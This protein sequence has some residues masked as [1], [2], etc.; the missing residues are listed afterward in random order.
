MFLV[1]HNSMVQKGN[2]LFTYTYLL[3]LENDFRLWLIS[4]NP[5]ILVHNIHNSRCNQLL[6]GRNNFQPIFFVVKGTQANTSDYRSKMSSLAHK[7]I[8][9]HLQKVFGHLKCMNVIALDTSE[10]ETMAQCLLIS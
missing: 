7:Q 3:L 1:L 6:M 4:K 10:R 5:L 8:I 2:Y 9:K